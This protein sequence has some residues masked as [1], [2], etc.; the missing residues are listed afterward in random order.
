VVVQI[1]RGAARDRPIR[2][3]LTG[4]PVASGLLVGFLIMYTTGML[5]Q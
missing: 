1:G 4:A 5:V 2:S 3:F